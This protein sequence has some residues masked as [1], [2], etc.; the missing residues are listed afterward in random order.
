MHK[1]QMQKYA[2]YAKCAIKNAKNAKSAKM[3]RNAKDM[4]NRCITEM[5]KRY[6][7]KQMHKTY[8]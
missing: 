7:Q 8:A 5:Q 2:K 1:K 4:L 6:V 3:Q